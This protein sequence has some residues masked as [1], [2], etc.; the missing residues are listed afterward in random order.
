MTAFVRNNKLATWLSTWLYIKDMISCYIE[1][2]F[3]IRDMLSLAQIYWI[4]IFITLDKYCYFSI[5]LCHYCPFE[6]YI[7]LD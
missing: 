6:F 3:E 4:F 1:L 5:L 7:V 2:A